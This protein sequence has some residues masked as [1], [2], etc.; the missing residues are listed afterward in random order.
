MLER[1]TTGEIMAIAISVTQQHYRSVGDKSP[2]ETKMKLSNFF[3][4]TTAV[5][6]DILLPIHHSVVFLAAVPSIS[7]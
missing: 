4:T 3:D 1:G 2:A 5:T 7:E 6:V